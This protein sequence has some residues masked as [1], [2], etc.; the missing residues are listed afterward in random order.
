MHVFPHRFAVCLSVC[1]VSASIA[2]AKQPLKKLTVD[3]GVPPV[4]LFDAIEAGTIETTVMAKNAHEA[5]LLVTN[6][7]DVPVTV[8]MPKA[9]V[10]V[11]V[12]KQQFF[13]QQNRLGN[14]GQGGPGGNMMGG[15]QPMGMGQNN[16]GNNNAF[17]NNAV[18]QNNFQ[19]NGFNN[20]GNGFNNGN[21]FF[22]VPPQ[23]TV[24][25]PMKG[26]CL[27]HG[28]P[29]PRPRMTYKLVKL[30]DFT[31]DPALRETLNVFGTSDVDLQA[32]QAA[33]WHLTDKMS[34]QTLREKRQE[35]WGGG[36][37]PAYFSEA[38]IDE[39]ENLI[40]QVR[41]KVDSTPRRAETAAR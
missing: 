27:A 12:L 15:A 34:W 38:Q 25:V 7:S 31:S 18:G 5:Q 24:Q 2:F 6:K 33:V 14:V 32:A 41:E 23:K 28:K 30:E 13:G 36:E 26:V 20:V 39:A 8:Q 4:G 10:A 1:L 19:G 22:S 16:M 9:V 21:G 37:P 3:S 11:Q 40:R 35:Q 29:D 17:G